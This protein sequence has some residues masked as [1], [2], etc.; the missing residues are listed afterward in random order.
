M[1]DTPK[2]QKSANKNLHDAIF[3][4]VY[5]SYRN[6]M[7][8]FRLIFSPY[9]FKLFDWETV[10]TESTEFWN[11]ELREKKTDLILSLKIKHSEISVRIFFLLEHKSG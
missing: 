4:D 10:R 7:D 6:V 5:S 11:E 8:L 2:P 3:R 1:A 9:E